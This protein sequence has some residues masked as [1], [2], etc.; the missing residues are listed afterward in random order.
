[1]KKVSEYEAHARECRDMADQMSNPAHKKQLIEMAEAW[2]M[3]VKVRVQQIGRERSQLLSASPLKKK[4][5]QETRPEA[6]RDGP[7]AWRR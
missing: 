2:E 6:V 5:P 1:M 7:F 3:L 4:R